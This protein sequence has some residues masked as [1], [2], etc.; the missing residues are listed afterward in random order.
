M[1]KWKFWKKVVEHKPEPA[2]SKNTCPHCGKHVLRQSSL[3][4]FAD[5]TPENQTRLSDFG[6]MTERIGMASQPRKY[7][8]SI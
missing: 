1:S 8:G 5:M 3:S 2:P 7:R 6:D 4:E